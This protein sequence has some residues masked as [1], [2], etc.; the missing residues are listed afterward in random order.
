MRSEEETTDG[1]PAANGDLATAAF[2]DSSH[3]ADPAHPQLK[4]QK[5]SHSRKR[6]TKPPAAAPSSGSSAARQKLRVRGDPPTSASA[7]AAASAKSGKAAG[8]GKLVSILSKE[9][10]QGAKRWRCKWE[11]GSE[12]RMHPPLRSVVP[13]LSLC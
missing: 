13:S 7:A 4:K 11:D 1:A 10:Y 6:A 5:R 8:R 3:R 12:V 9:D 2:G